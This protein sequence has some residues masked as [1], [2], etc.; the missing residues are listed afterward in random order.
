MADGFS[1]LTKDVLYCNDHDLLQDDVGQAMVDIY[2]A[3]V[4]DETVAGMLRRL[5]SK[6]RLR[7]AFH[8]E[9]PFVAARL[10]NGNYLVGHGLDGKELWSEVQFL[11]AHSLT[12]AGSGAGKTMMARHKVLQVAAFVSGMFLFDLRKREFAV[13]KR[14]LQ[15][16]GIHLR[17]LTGRSLRTNPLQ[18]PV[19]VT[20]SDWVPRVADMLI[21]V[22]GLPPRASKLIQTVLFRLYRQFESRPGEWPTL[23]DLF[24]AIKTDAAANHQ[25][26]AAILDSLEPVLLSLGPQVL[27]WRRG[28]SSH[29]LAKLHLAIELGGVSETDKNLLLN[30]LVLSEFTSRIARGISNPKMDLWICLDEAQRLCCGAN[31]TSA[32]GDLIGLVRGT[33]IG[34]DLS[35]QSADGVLPAVV[36]NTATKTMGRCGSMADYASAGGSMGLSREQIQWAQMNLTPGVFIERLAE[37]EWRKPFVFRVP[38]INV[39]TVSGQTQPD[40]DLGLDT[41]FASE[42]A[43]WDETPEIPVAPPATA[44][45][46]PFESDQEYRFCKAVADNPMQ[47]SSTYPKPAGIATKSAKGI[48]DSLV[49]KGFLVEHPF[50]TG[51]RGRASILLEA[52]PAG[53][54]A[55]RAHEGGDV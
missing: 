7:V 11:N 15:E 13:L 31:G 18:L 44:S 50:H 16:R 35:L 9:A 33:G 24:E 23:F 45:P 29:D 41:V 3:G 37:G 43:R 52:T 36:S 46:S 32:I 25:A 14:R 26:R 6:H 47:P 51:R 20:V 19:G 28:W 27:A 54:A 34:L 17:V 8:G 12:V 2:R 1:Q 48:R 4:A 38:L 21:G 22:F 10:T 5:A 42:F 40:G 53:Q 55:V 49:A 30:T 39:P